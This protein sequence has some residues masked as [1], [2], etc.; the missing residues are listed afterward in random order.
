M[1]DETEW[2]PD[3]VIVPDVVGELVD[4]A[5]RVAQTVGVVLAQPDAD[6]APLSALTWRLPV[7]VTSQSPQAGTVVRRH[8]SVV[9]TWASGWSGV[10]E[11]RRPMPRARGGLTERDPRGDPPG[12]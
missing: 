9:V 3:E 2:F 1:D 4:D 6:G 10:R 11:P 12:A 5:R 7:A 8:D